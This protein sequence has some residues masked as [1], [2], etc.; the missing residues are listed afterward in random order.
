MSDNGVVTYM[1]GTDVIVV[2]PTNPLPV[3]ATVTIPGTVAVTQSGVWLDG[4]KGTDGAT[5]A[6]PTNPFDVQPRRATTGA[7]TSV[8]GSV[9][10]VTILAANSAREGATVYNESSAVLYLLLANTV[11]SIT[12]YTLQVTGGSYYEVPFGYTGII[13]GIW[14]SATG[15]ARITEFT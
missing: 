14:A 15:S 5:I 12:V 13:K 4:V 3:T 9:T 6:S 10:D 2:S 1:S 8:A 11:S 7:Q